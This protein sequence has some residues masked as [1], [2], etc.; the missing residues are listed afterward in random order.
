MTQNILAYVDD[1][2]DVIVFAYLWMAAASLLILS[3]SGAHATVAPADLEWTA[4]PGWLANPSSRYRHSSS[5]DTARFEVRQAG[6]GM[7][8]SAPLPQPVDLSKRPWILVKYRARD[9]VPPPDY[10]V[11]LG[12]QSGEEQYIAEPS[13]LVSDGYWHTIV[14]RAK[15][16]VGVT[17][18]VQLQSASQG[19]VL[20]ISRL[21]FHESRPDLLPEDVLPLGPQTRGR[22]EQVDIRTLCNE[23][24]RTLAE[25]L[26][27]REWISHTQ[28]AI[29]GVPFALL[30]DD[31][32]TASTS[33]DKPSELSIPLSDRPCSELFFLLG[34][35]PDP[36]KDM[37]LEG[38]P[39]LFSVELT[40]S[41]GTVDS[42]IPARLSGGFGLARGVHVYAVAAQK[43]KK[44][45]SVSIRDNARGVAI[46][47]VALTVGLDTRVAPQAHDEAFVRP[48]PYATPDG[49]GFRRWSITTDDRVLELRDGHLLTTITLKPGIRFAVDSGRSAPGISAFGSL[50]SVRAG[51]REYGS[52]DF[53]ATDVRTIGSRVTIKFADR[54]GRGMTGELSLDTRSP[55]LL[56]MTL[57]LRSRESTGCTVTFPTLEN[58]ADSRGADVW[59]CFPR[60]GSVVANSPIA[61]REPYS[62]L[63]P[64]QFADVYGSSGGVYLRTE[65]LD[66]TYRYFILQTD[67]RRVFV[68]CEYMEG[69]I[70]PEAEFRSVPSA[71][72][73]HAGDWHAALDAYKEWV[74]TWYRPDAPRKDWFR[75]VF[76]FRQQFPFRRYVP[77]GERYFDPATCEYSFDEGIEADRELFGGIDYLHLFD[78]GASSKYGR[79]GD[80]EPWDEIGGVDAFRDAVAKTQDAGVPVGLYIEGYLVDPQSKVGQAHGKEWELR[81]REGRPYPYFAPS[82]NMCSAVKPWQDYLA[83]VYRR[84]R[85][86]TGAMGYYCDEMGFADPWHFCYSEEHGHP[87]P[88]PPSR[89]QRE[90]LRKVRKAIGPEA[91][92]YTEET[93]PDAITQHLDGSFSYVYSPAVVRQWCDSHVNMTRFALPDFKTIQIINCDRPLGDHLTAVRRIFFNGEAIWLEGPAEW[94]SPEVLE[95]IRRM[96]SVMR[97][98][99]DCFTSMS[100]VPL[101]PTGHPK[102]FANQFPGEGRTLWTL[103]NASYSTVRGEI[104]A[105]KHV[106]GAVYYDPWNE[107]FL[108]PSIYGDVALIFAEL[109]PRGTGCVVQTVKL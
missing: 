10:L 86:Q 98:Y 25:R 6:T 58:I 21:E 12:G 31:R 67:Y 63:M 19:S 41:D 61:L 14:T 7:K 34:A 42:R 72:G 22:F 83:S 106:P 62:G 11:W 8:W 90:L 54:H 95:Y 78:W 32:S 71:I 69:S 64:L 15:P 91:V 73:F 103:F 44:I 33:A 3:L 50:W 92:L 57:S 36:G 29:S 100:P 24:V 85:S 27:L 66:T 13:S 94:F 40:Y 81:D 75:R 65:D 107:T 52:H 82:M 93:P 51:E 70:G 96:H 47:L 79:C 88:E 28:A 99:A 39:H 105:V 16:F 37:P 68:G 26:G 80:Y 109:G 77:G 2:E 17:V 23:N 18:A 30:H 102:V 20:E 38:E 48:E 74:G 46:A 45:R 49:P 43:D 60:R 84:V 97:E 9:A 1:V 59:Y 5:D 56:R 89:G 104:L 35:F 53:V 87:V 76:N 4:Q 55:G 108:E 101:I